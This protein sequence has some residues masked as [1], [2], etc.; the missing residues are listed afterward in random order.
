MLR[1]IIV[2]LSLILWSGHAAPAQAAN[3]SLAHT[4]SG[5]TT[6]QPSSPSAS[7]G[8]GLIT[9]DIATIIVFPSCSAF[10]G[11]LT[12]KH[13]LCPIEAVYE[14]KRNLAEGRLDVFNAGHI[15][16]EYDLPDLA[17][18]KHKLEIPLPFYWQESKETVPDPMLFCSLGTGSVTIFSA[19]LWDNSY[20]GESMYDYKPEPPQ[21]PDEEPSDAAA[22]YRGNEVGITSFDVDWKLNL[23]RRDVGDLPE[24]EILGVGFVEGAAVECHKE[25][26]PEKFDTSPLRDVRV[27]STISHQAD[28]NIPELKAARFTVPRGVFAYPSHIQIVGKVKSEPSATT[29]K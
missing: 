28:P 20:S 1:T 9:N 26:N 16:E 17:V 11:E 25:A 10:Q 12:G 14:L 29:G 21:N 18:G 2:I 6:S 4:S 19:Q 23:K 27:V 5:Q 8:S 15:E 24:I 7:A 13:R 22:A 3:Q